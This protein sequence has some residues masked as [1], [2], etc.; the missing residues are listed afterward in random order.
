MTTRACLL[1]A[2][3]LAAC[4]HSSSAASGPAAT[5][6]DTGSAAPATSAAAADPSAIANPSPLSGGL[7]VLAK[8][9]AWN[10]ALDSHN[11]AA[12]EPLYFKHICYYGRVVALGEVLKQKKDAL[13]ATSTFHQQIV[14]DV[15]FVQSQAGFVVARFTKRSGLA[16]RLRDTQARVVLRRDADSDELRILEE[17]DD[18]GPPVD[19]TA[20]ACAQVAWSA[21]TRERCEDAASRV[22][23][24]MPGV[25]K[26]VDELTRASTEGHAMGGIGPQ[27]NGDGT[28]SASIGVQTPERFEGRVDYTV[29]RAT[30]HL[31]VSID[32][33]DAPVP[34]NAQRQLAN[35][36]EP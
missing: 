36:C 32:G 33:T 23:N 2:A 13:G 17:A 27:D 19:S 20:D 8:V 26:V 16:A 1:V 12:L 34:E 28:F 7:Q 35:A 31:T 29:Q 11:V 3:A 24:A 30:G 5:A 25:K 22:V 21:V 10:E 15:R 9:R 6:S 18:S 14:G 4:S